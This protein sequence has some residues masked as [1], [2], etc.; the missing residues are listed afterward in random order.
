MKQRAEDAEGIV[1]TD[2]KF[3]TC[4]PYA[5]DAR[6]TAFSLQRSV[7]GPWI[8]KNY[9]VKDWAN[10]VERFG[11]PFVKGTYRGDAWEKQRS[12]LQTAIKNM[13]GSGYGL[14]AEGV[15]IELLTHTVTTFPHEALID[16]CNSEMSKA[17]LGQT[18]TTEPGDRGARSL[19]EVH[20]DVEASL[21]YSDALTEAETL[22]PMLKQLTAI[23]F[24]PEAPVPIFKR[25]LQEVA[26]FTAIDAQIR[27]AQAAGIK[28]VSLAWMLDRLQIEAPANVD[29]VLE[30]SSPAP[31]PMYPPNLGNFGV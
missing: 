26:D 18:L 30:L 16:W 15:D 21:I 24:G 23:Q 27:A 7:C 22:A 1:V 6:P 17:F 5:Y 29:D 9:G 8:I 20:A 19:G 31:A 2:D 3:I 28:R 10:A 14:F 4:M 13:A 25:E 12:T 11:L